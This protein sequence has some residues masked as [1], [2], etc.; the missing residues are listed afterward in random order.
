MPPASPAAPVR[1]PLSCSA[2]R[3]RPPGSGG[4]RRYPSQHAAHL[5]Q[6][7]RRRHDR[8]P[9]RGPGLQGRS[10]ARGV[11]HPR[12]GGRGARARSGAR[13]R[14]RALGRAPRAAAGAVRGRRGPR[15]Q[16]GPTSQA[17]TRRVAG[18]PRD[19]RAAGV[20]DRRARRG[21]SPAERLHRPRREPRLGVPRPRPQHDPPRRAARGRA[22]RVGRRGQR[23]RVP[24]PEPAL[25]RAVRPRARRGGRDGADQPDRGTAAR[26]SGRRRRSCR[27]RTAG[28]A[29]RCRRP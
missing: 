25:G 28:P 9:L 18:L 4:G 26:R 21:P 11:R 23:G 14:P 6:D 27:R 20:A 10:R 1:A 15:D 7:R 16:P 17:R 5:H 29:A 8:A 2:G 3:L 24:L 12:R 13:G 19:G 22:P